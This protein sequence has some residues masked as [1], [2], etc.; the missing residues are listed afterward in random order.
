[1]ALDA[2]TAQALAILTRDEE[3]RK[4]SVNEI[5]TDMKNSEFFRQNWDNLLLAAPNCLEILGNIN[6]VASTPWAEATPLKGKFRYLTN[7]DYLRGALA[8]ISSQGGRSFGVARSNMTKIQL[9]SGSVNEQVRLLVPHIGILG[10][11]VRLNQVKVIYKALATP[12]APMAAIM[13]RLELLKETAVECH[14]SAKQIEESMN[15]WAEFVYELYEVCNNTSASVEDDKR[16]TEQQL[17]L[18]AQ[19]KE[20]REKQEKDAKAELAKMDEAL[21]DAKETYKEALDAMPTG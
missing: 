3:N 10:L 11:I 20:F 14:Q 17:K 19:D 21:K 16:R 15:L 2:P 12:S 5:T 18:A 7:S 4:V 6:L 1:M 8:C 13:A 9:S